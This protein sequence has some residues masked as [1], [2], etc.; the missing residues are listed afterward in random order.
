MNRLSWPIVLV[1]AALSAPAPDAW[2]QRFPHIG[3]VYPAGG[4]QG[5]EFEVEVGGQYLNGVTHADISG[6]GV[7]AMLVKH[8]KPLTQ[9][10]LNELRQKL[11]EFQKRLQAAT[12]RRAKARGKGGRVAGPAT[13]KKIAEDVGLQAT[14]MKDI[15]AIRK[16][17]FDPKRQ[18]NPQL[19]ERVILR[20]TVAPGTDP[21]RRDLRLKTATGVSN[22]IALHVGQWP[23]YCENEP[24]NTEPQTV[25]A[26]QR[27]IVL[28]GQIQPGDVDRFR[29]SAR[30]GERLVAAASARAL[31][32]YLADAVPGW[33]QATLALYDDTG[34]E[35]AY[36]D[37]YRFNPDPVLYYEVPEDG[38]YVVEIKDAIYRGREDFVYRITLGEIPFVT[39]IFPLGGQAGGQTT[40]TLDGWNLPVKKKTIRADGTAPGIQH[41]WVGTKGRLSN[42]VPFAVDTLP[43]CLEQE[44]NNAIESAQPVKLPCVINGHIDHVGDWDVF[45][46]EGRAGQRLVADVQAR[47]LGSPVDSLLKLTDAKG[48]I[49]AANDDHE[50]KGQGLATHHA[51]SQFS[52]PIPADGTYYLHV[53]DTQNQGG[54]AY[55]Y[56]LRISRPRP[57]FELRVVPSTINARGSAIVPIMVYALRKDGFA[58]GIALGLKDAPAGFTLS[59]ARVPPHQDSV[60]LTLSVP[61]KPRIEPYSLSLEGRATIKGQGICRQAVPAEDMMQA[62]IYR[63]LVPS[64]DW[65]VAVT[66]RTRSLTK[67]LPV[68]K[69]PVQLAAGTTTR[70]QLSI[71]RGVR[72]NQ[73]LLALHEPPEGIAITNVSV[74]RTIVT[75]V[76]RTE[77][78]TVKPGVRGNL[79]VNAFTERTPR[80]KNPT[81]K[82][83]KR[84][85][86]LGTLPAIPFEIVGQK[87]S[88]I[89]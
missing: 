62:F 4:R 30:T 63:H 45:Q 80:A 15:A 51:D 26:P 56:R 57:D 17:L 40:V 21:G 36:A 72:A 41:V 14:T 77:A 85:V 6:T 42:S 68:G 46:V 53:S 66:G 29:F 83:K 33:F 2:A 60:W 48:A 54:A 88:E 76:L 20:I 49:L 74:S 13:V 84:R 79:I 61:P 11:R 70:V 24:N 55:G 78:D 71:P 67:V 23:E 73:L 86:L 69:K 58:G 1:L 18:P 43:E 35:V 12:R 81:A 44:S 28:N 10:E 16:K 8:I 27:P 64:K 25:K 65:L 22:P 37:D 75:M 50:D 5:T 87:R 34:N 32:P 19:A 39:T 82:V 9:K 38:Q 89:L 59:G 31:I 3:Y 7:Q 47:R 52:A